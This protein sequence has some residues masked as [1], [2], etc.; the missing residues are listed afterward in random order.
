LR[1]VHLTITNIVTVGIASVPRKA[2]L[3][4][5]RGPNGGILENI[6]N[7]RCHPKTS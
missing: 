3:M 2:Y 5:I 4:N 1:K 7:L 6:Q